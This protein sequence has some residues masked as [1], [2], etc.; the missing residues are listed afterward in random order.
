MRSPL[1]E[2]LSLVEVKDENTIVQV[3]LIWTKILNSL[4]RSWPP[5]TFDS[6]FLKFQASLLEKTLDHLN[7]TISENTINFW[8]CT[9]G[10]QVHL[11]YPQNLLPVLDKLSRNEKINICKTKLASNGKACSGVTSSF[12]D[13]RCTVTATLSHCSKRVELLGDAIND[14]LGIN[15]LQLSSKREWSELTE[16]Q[17]E[18]RRAQQGRAC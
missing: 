6:S 14:L 12:A 7:F 4:Q 8:N 18:V 11:D 5:I 9:Y 3:Q 10:E 2:W 1:L 16:H 15:K 13:E 17:K